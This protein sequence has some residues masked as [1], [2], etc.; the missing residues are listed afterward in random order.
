MAILAMAVSPSR[1]LGPRLQVAM[2]LKWPL[3]SSS[4]KPRDSKVPLDLGIVPLTRKTVPPS[5]TSG[6]H[7]QR[8]RGR[9]GWKAMDVEC[10]EP[11]HSCQEAK[12]GCR[13]CNR[14][15]IL[16]SIGSAAVLT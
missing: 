5:C 9:E 6:K 16:A 15:R 14:G 11:T 1:R 4:E 8:Y 13:R 12:S 7:R 10:C 2:P 3:G